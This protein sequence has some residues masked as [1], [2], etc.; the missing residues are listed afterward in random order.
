LSFQQY[1]KGQTLYF[2]A[3]PKLAASELAPW[4]YFG[5]AA[6]PTAVSF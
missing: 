2:R 3:A 5:G 1:L 6:N 4:I